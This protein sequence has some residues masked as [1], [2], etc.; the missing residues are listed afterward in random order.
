MIPIP[1][2]SAGATEVEPR[3]RETRQERSRRDSATVA[4]T[5]DPLERPARSPSLREEEIDAAIEMTFPASDP[6]AWMSSGSR[7]VLPEATD[8]TAPATD[9]N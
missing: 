7:P 9:E 6:P 5:G 2:Q 3:I 1:D 4:S 8:N